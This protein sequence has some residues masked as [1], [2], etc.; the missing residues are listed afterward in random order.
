M[1]TSQSLAIR[2]S[3]QKARSCCTLWTYSSPGLVVSKFPPASA[4]KSTTTEPSFID[5]IISLL[6][7]TGAFLPGEIK[8]NSTNRH[9]SLLYSQL[10]SQGLILWKFSSLQD[11]PKT[12][13]QV[14]PAI[15]FGKRCMCRLQRGHHS[16][17]PRP[18][19]RLGLSCLGHAL[20][21]WLTCK[22]SFT[23]RFYLFKKNT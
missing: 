12:G 10:Q 3:R 4:A 22:R 16:P 5:S 23:R 20:P 6:N 18:H 9:V 21:S 7:R 1:Q 8:D 14:R 13:E 11:P 2:T 19:R 15:L 17:A